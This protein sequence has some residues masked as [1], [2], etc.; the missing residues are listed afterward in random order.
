MKLLVVIP[1]YNHPQTIA[2]VVGEMRSHGWPVLVVDDGSDETAKAVLHAVAEADAQVQIVWR[3]HNGGKGAAVKDGLQAA[4]DQGYSHVLQVDADAQHQLSDA[5]SLVAAAKS[6]P[7]AVVCAEPIYGDDAPKAR[8]YGRQLTNFWVWVNTG[9]RAIRDGMCGFRVYSLAAVMPVLAHAKMGNRM[10]FDA[11]ILV[12]LVWARVPL[13]WLP[14]PVRYAAD[15][16]SHFQAWRDNFLIAKMHAR[17]FFI[18][19]WRW[20]RH[21][22]R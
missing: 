18:M 7:E 9:S 12:R 2:Y 19:V 21:G 10:D 16:V 8:L 14:T 5:L 1:H 20:I 6:Q 22:S 3:A 11:D 4:F 17:L 15:G 13:L